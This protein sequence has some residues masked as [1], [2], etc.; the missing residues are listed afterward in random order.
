MLSNATYTRVNL[1][2]DIY[3]VRNARVRI[4][5]LRNDLTAITN[6]IAQA[7]AVIYD[8]S[9]VS[10]P[11]S[12]SLSEPANAAEVT[13]PFARVDGVAPSS[14]AAEAVCVNR[15]LSWFCKPDVP[16]A[17]HAKGGPCC[18]IRTF[19]EPVVHIF[20]FTNAGR[21]GGGE[22]ECGYCGYSSLDQM[23]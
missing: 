1:N 16:L 15:F 19:D 3:Q 13:K 5:E 20:I 22:R 18:Q 8:P 14:P 12:L 10:A 23:L 6:D 2:A 4:I 17:G 21:A 11:E 7:L 9:A